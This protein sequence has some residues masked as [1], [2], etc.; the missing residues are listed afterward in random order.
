MTG[1]YLAHYWPFVR[2]I[3]RPSVYSLTK[4]QLVKASMFVS[5][6]MQSFDLCFRS[7][8]KL[9]NK[10]KSPQWDAMILMWHHWNETGYF[11]KLEAWTNCI[12]FKKNFAIA[13]TAKTLQ[14]LTCMSATWVYDLHECNISTAK[15]LLQLKL[16]VNSHECTATV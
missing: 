10:E 2:R 6:V 8:N 15:R 9:L 13:L 3:H 7:Q 12:F 5:L 4:D 16:H 11:Q 1:K 14:T